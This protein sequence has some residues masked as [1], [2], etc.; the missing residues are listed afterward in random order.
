MISSRQLVATALAALAALVIAAPTAGAS[1]GSARQPVPG[2][3]F[4]GVP[5]AVPLDAGSCGTA[6]SLGVDAGAGGNETKVCAGTGPVFIGPSIGQ[7]ATVIGPTIIGPATIGA[8]GVS[9]GS[10]LIG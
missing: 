6:T 8:L 3:P 2:V 4:G 1:A 5:G 9:G 7:I 10:V